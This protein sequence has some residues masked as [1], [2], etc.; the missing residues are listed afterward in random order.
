MIDY[1]G[2]YN[3]K[4]Y[5]ADLYTDHLVDRSLRWSVLEDIT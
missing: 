3:K 1:D 5:G 2:L 4:Y